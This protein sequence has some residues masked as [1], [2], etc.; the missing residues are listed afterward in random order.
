MSRSKRL[1]LL[2]GIICSVCHK[3]GIETASYAVTALDDNA[4]FIRFQEFVI[5]EY[6]PLG[7]DDFTA[8]VGH[9]CFARLVVWPK[10]F[11][12]EV[13]ESIWKLCNTVSQ[14]NSTT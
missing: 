2:F 12:S 7:M 10:I 6:L 9:E 13:L 1:S 14:M 5:E 4:M 8:T 11:S 3:P